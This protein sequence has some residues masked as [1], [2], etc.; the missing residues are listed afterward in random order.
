MNIENSEL[1]NF[2][3]DN[4]I[5]CSS[6]TLTDLIKNLEIE[7]NK[8]TE[9]FKENNMTVYPEKFQSIIIDRKGQNNNPTKLIIEVNE[10]QV[11]L[12]HFVE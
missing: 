11:S 2:A 3:D 9:W 8:A 10:M 1:H 12:M 7:S 5:T 4:T 6:D